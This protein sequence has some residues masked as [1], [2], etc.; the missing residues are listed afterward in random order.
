MTNIQTKAQKRRGALARL[1]ESASWSSVTVDPV[2]M[3]RV[4]IEGSDAEVL[5]LIREAEHTRDRRNR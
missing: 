4:A 5:D 3:K 2:R 1:A